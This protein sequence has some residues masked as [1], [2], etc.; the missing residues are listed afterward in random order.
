RFD[1]NDRV[2]SQL[3]ILSPKN[4]LSKKNSSIAPLAAHFP[5][6]ISENDLQKLDNEWRLLGNTKLNVDP[7][8]SIEEF[9]NTVENMRYGDDS[10]MF[11]VLTKFVFDILIFPHSSANVERTFSDVNLL[12]TNR[13]NK[14]STSSIVGNLHAKTYLRRRNAT[15]NS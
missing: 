12:K 10:P 1:F 7:D 9:W 11:P 4:V 8:V 6:L 2:L 14:L 5:N 3:S 13:R 15:C